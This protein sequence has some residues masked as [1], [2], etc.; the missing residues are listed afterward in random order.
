[1]SIPASGGGLI[2]YRLSYPVQSRMGFEFSWFQDDGNLDNIELDASLQDGANIW[3]AVIKWQKTGTMGW[4]YKDHNGV[5]Q[6]IGTTA[7]YHTSSAPFNHAKLVADFLNKEFVKLIANDTEYDLAGIDLHTYP[8]T[9]VP[10]LTC[11]IDATAADAGDHVC[12]I[13]HFIVTRNEP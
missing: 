2:Q 3:K 11:T 13:G 12:H 9:V 7:N 1:M 6:L 10:L 4:Y 8:S 5:W